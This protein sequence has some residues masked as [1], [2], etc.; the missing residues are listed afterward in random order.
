MKLLEWKELPPSLQNGSVLPYYNILKRHPWG[1]FLKRIFDIIAALMMLLLLLPIILIVS[2]LIRLDSEGPI[3]FKQVRVTQYGKKFKILKFRTMVVNAES[4]G[5]QVTLMNDARITKV[6]ARLRKYRID[7]IPQLINIFKG[8]MSFVGTRPEVVKYIE[9]YTDEMKATLL[10]RAGLT[11]EASIKYKDE[12]EIMTG[13]E[14][15][16]RV[17]IEKVLPEKM[18][19][20]LRSMEN[21]GFLAELGIMVRTVLAVFK[22]DDDEVESD[23]KAIVKRQNGVKML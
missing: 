16:D 12:E 21:F 23:N 13:A 4:I 7:E 5:S 1:I 2:V 18:K 19:I 14:D 8:E 17:Y 6:G 10:L 22:R 3:F 11:S 20:N 9:A 15:A